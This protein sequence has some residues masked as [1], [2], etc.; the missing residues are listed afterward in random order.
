MYKR[1]APARRRAAFGAA[2]SPAAATRRAAARRR[3]ATRAAAAESGREGVKSDKEMAA[4]V[5]CELEM[6]R[7]TA[8]GAQSVT[9]NGEAKAFI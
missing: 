5:I 2:P 6:V 4:S 7:R 1:S 3:W 8:V 9:W